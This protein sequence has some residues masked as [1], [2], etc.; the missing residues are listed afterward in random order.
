MEGMGVTAHQ[1]A[2]VQQR[3]V[4]FTVAGE[5]QHLIRD[6]LVGIYV[7]TVKLVFMIEPSINAHDIGINNR[8]RL[9]EGVGEDRSGRVRTKVGDS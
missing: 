4:E 3:E 2:Q 7:V 6:C 8:G 1:S 9:V 5:G